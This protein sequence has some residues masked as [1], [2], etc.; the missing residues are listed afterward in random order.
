AESRLTL[1][2]P[3]G[4]ETAK[5]LKRIVKEKPAN[6][7]GHSTATDLAAKGRATIYEGA[8]SGNGTVVHTTPKAAPVGFSRENPYTA[9]VLKSE[10]LNRP[11]SEKETRHVEI[12][13][14]P[15]GPSYSVGDSLGIYPDNCDALAEDLIAAVGA[16]GDEPV[17]LPT[18]AETSLRIA[19]LRDCCLNE[20]SELLLER[21][22]DAATDAGESARLRGL[23]D[24][25]G[26][27]AGHDVLDVL[28]AFPSARLSPEE[29]VASLGPVKPR[30]Y[31]IS[32]SPK[33]HA[34]QVH[35]TVRRVD[36]QFNGRVRKGVASTMLADR[37]SPG[38]PVR[39]FV[40][41]SHGF[42]L[43][44][45]PDAP[46]ILIGPGTGI[47]P[48]RAFLHERDATGARGRN[49]LFYGDQR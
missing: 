40:Q 45:D 2:S 34:G 37:V 4:S 29:L 20:V 33:R 15:D 13:L 25:D 32:S 14:G 27:I 19:L 35:L 31:S 10:N 46:T 1:C 21:M 16:R 36:Y 3:G 11:G 49:W 24:E 6:G 42:S 9:R 28:R 7:D 48:F 26:P 39:V 12:E 8:T 41:P 18:G 43:P 17:R 23:I 22:A 38:S 47:A 44:A 5:T 30:L